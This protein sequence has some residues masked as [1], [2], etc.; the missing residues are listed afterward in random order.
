[1]KK[2]VMLFISFVFFLNL[3][4]QKKIDL[5]EFNIDQLNLYKEKA[6]KMEHTGM[7]ITFVGGAAAIMSGTLLFNEFLKPPPDYDLKKESIFA[8][9]MLSGIVTAGVGIPL[10]IT[11]DKR[12]SKAEIAL[13]KFDVKIN[14]SMAIGLGL[15]AMF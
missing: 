14:N 7:I 3:M 11:G 10:W 6:V 5:S 8:H 15:K 2:I 4:A 1:M 9:I 13:K 12:K